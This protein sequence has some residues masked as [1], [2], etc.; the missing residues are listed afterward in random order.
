MTDLQPAGAVTGGSVPQDTFPPDPKYGRFARPQ[1]ETEHLEKLLVKLG[2]GW[3]RNRSK[4]L[5]G[6]RWRRRW[7]L[8]VGSL[9]VVAGAGVM[10]SMLDAGVGAGALVR[11][12]TMAPAQGKDMLERWY[13]LMSVYPSATAASA[14]DQ[15][16]LTARWREFL[17]DAIGLIALGRSDLLV[18]MRTKLYS[19]LP[20]RSDQSPEAAFGP[21][22]AEQRFLWPLRDRHSWD[23]V[24]DHGLPLLSAALSVVALLRA[25]G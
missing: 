7:P 1:L 3:P 11:P 8:L 15:A 22:A 12:H 25:V 4:K 24:K 19:D 20:H 18:D 10:T 6:Y 14:L 13:A 17:I 9:D 23:L 16:N 2:Q 5:T 21:D